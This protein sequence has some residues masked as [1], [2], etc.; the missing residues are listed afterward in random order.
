[1]VKIPHF[2][3]LESLYLS[4]IPEEFDIESFY[5]FATGNQKTEFD[6][7]FSFEISLDYQIRLSAVVDKILQT[8]NHSYQIPVMLFDGMT[9]EMSELAMD[10]SVAFDKVR[11]Q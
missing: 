5:D 10:R 6:F 1:M 8:E 2:S 7:I 11:K 3:N 9:R 4:E